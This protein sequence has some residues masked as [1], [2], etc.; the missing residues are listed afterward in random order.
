MDGGI[1]EDPESLTLSVVFRVGSWES[2]K[3][4][5]VCGI[6]SR[7]PVLNDC[8]ELQT[9]EGWALVTDAKESRDSIPT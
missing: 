3:S 2:G 9:P 4:N 8:D 7:I 6:P 5:L 1:Y